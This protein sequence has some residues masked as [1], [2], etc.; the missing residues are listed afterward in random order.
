MYYS[1]VLKAVIDSLQRAVDEACETITK[2]CDENKWLSDVWKF[3]N[4]WQG[5]SKVTSMSA[6]ELEV[7]KC[8]G[9]Q[10]NSSCGRHLLRIMLRVSCKEYAS[11]SSL[12]SQVGRVVLA[13]P[14]L[15]YMYSVQCRLLIGPN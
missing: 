13:N 8:Y 12:S 9:N 15:S 5:R 3:V 1:E 14:A 10:L 2:T 4:S 6:E 7:R 11:S